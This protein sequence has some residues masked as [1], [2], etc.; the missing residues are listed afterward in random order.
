[1]KKVT[2]LLLLILPAWSTWTL[3]QEYSA[4]DMSFIPVQH[5][6]FVIKSK[7]ATIYVDPVGDVQAFK[8][9][10]PPDII[11]L[12]DI[13]RDHFAPTLIQS[14][15]QKETTIV[16]PPNVVEKLLYGETLKNGEKKTVNNIIIEAIPMYNL[17]PERAKFHP[18]GRG[19]GYVI[20][21]NNKR[22]YISGDTEDIPEMR[23]LKKIDYAFL[24]MNLPYTMNVEQAASAVLEMKPKVVLPYHYR[25]KGGLSDLE[26]FR[27]LT[28]G[29]RK[30]TF[31]N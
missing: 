23:S 28:A 14:L 22:I 1:M 18:K 11:L 29:G 20:A 25:G 31:I 30:T 26:K 2:I 4:G 13:H 7:S 16:G 21:L 17:T 6:T 19:N 3:A 27:T 24:C 15:K 5:A 8:N 10:P 12:T 9:F